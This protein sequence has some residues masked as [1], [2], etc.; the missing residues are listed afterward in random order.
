MTFRDLLLRR[1]KLQT[2]LRALEALHEEYLDDRPL[3]LMA[4]SDL[5][6]ALLD[7]ERHLTRLGQAF[8]PAGKVFAPRE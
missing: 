7:E 6:Q 4:A 3:W 2:A 1:Q 8:V 5:R